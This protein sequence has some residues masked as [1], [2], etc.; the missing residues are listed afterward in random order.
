MPNQAQK[1]DPPAAVSEMSR[2]QVLALLEQRTR[3]AQSEL[4]RRSDAGVDVL[5]YLAENGAVATRRAV[6]ANLGAAPHTNRYLADDDDDEVRV[7]LARKI[8]RLMPDLGRDQA[9]HLQE[10]TIET[11]ERLARDELP[12]VRAALAESIKSL[13][14]IPKYIVL[15]LARDAE[16]LVAAP[17]VEYSP[18]LSDT[19]LIEIIAT[20]K[21]EE[22]I[23]AVA[24]RKPVNADVAD[25]VVA[26]LDIPAI[27]ALLAN[28]DAVVRER[29]M[30]SIINQ[31][32]SLEELRKPLT[33]RTDLSKRAILRIASFVGA[34]LIEQ[35]ILRYGLDEEIKHHLNKALRSRLQEPQPPE[36]ASLDA[37]KRDV[38]A[39]QAAGKLD[40]SFVDTAAGAGQRDVVILS[41]SALANVPEAIVR[42]II[43]SGSAKPAIALVWHAGLSMRVAFKIQSSVMKL[44][45]GE[46]L[47]ARAGVHFPLTE[48]EM[49]WHL[50][51]FDVAM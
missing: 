39:A 51:Y 42:K 36:S 8:A 2:E 5:H 35:L 26:S 27:S 12:R 37:A 47:P 11:M 44:S 16:T 46:L 43:Q 49:R 15:T 29:A 17:I 41:L 19:D 13:D 1:A 40:E 10:Q 22:I 32:E 45:V 28:P 14:C 33:L 3:A 31:A 18:L 20:A 23:A 30:D 48:D 50:G 21:A 38:A 7:E 4:A 34:S 6:A 25:A 9:R 24:R